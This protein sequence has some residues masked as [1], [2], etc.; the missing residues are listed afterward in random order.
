MKKYQG[1]ILGKQLT[2]DPVQYTFRAYYVP[3]EIRD[4]VRVVSG[5]AIDITDRTNYDFCAVH[6]MLFE[7]AK[8]DDRC[9]QDLATGIQ[10]PDGWELLAEYPL[11][12]D[13]VPES[14]EVIQEG[15][16]RA[17]QHLRERGIID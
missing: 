14:L 10:V 4:G 1:Y 9:F 2:A 15:E 5:E 16:E 6:A 11:P 12:D 7:E 3:V 8:G 13:Y 17:R